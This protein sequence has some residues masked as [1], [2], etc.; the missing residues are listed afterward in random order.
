MPDSEALKLTL[1]LV[2]QAAEVEFPT[3]GE[4]GWEQG[5][6]FAV[7]R[8][9]I[10]TGSPYMVAEGP[11]CL[12]AGCFAGHYAFSQGFIEPLTGPRGAGLRNPATGEI[13]WASAPD[14]QDDETI[15]GYARDGLGLDYDQGDCLFCAN[16]TLDDL[17]DIVDDLSEGD[18]A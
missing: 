3:P 6:W 4:I 12:T 16:N 9:P 2:E 5:E 7:K 15:A 13:L 17:R 10:D 14:D 8:V 11:L 18:D 1:K